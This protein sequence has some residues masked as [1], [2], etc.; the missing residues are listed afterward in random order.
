MCYEVAVN[1][2]NIPVFPRLATVAEVH[3]RA[4]EERRRQR[5]MLA[6]TREMAEQQRLK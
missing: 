5:E 3:R 2:P 1:F 6:A 4:R